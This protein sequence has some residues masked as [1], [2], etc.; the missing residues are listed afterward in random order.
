MEILFIS[1]EVAPLAKTGGLAD[2]CS[3]LPVALAKVG[4]KVDIIL[5]LYRCIKEGNFPLELVVKDLPLTFGWR[6]LKTNIYQT[7]LEKGIRV[8]LVKCDEFFDRSSLYGKD[9][10]YFDNGERFIFFNKAVLAF[11]ESFDQYWD[12]F[13]CHEWQTA[14]VPVY[15][16]TLSAFY[17]KLSSV[18]TVLTLHNLGYQGIFPP[19]IF[20]FCSAN[21][22]TIPKIGFSVNSKGRP[23]I[24]NK[25]CLQIC[26]PLRSKAE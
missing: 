18:K 5:P 1:P 25:S 13:H 6:N 2:V 17:H 22:V 26:F 10:G 19:E 14:L 21:L 11:A 15:L 8:F 7:K 3:A 9:N 23:H 4:I 24:F 20:P 16:K 12:I